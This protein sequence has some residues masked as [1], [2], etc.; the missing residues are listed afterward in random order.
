MIAAN[1]KRVNLR[2]DS[3]EHHHEVQ[4]IAVSKTRSNSEI[5]EAVN[6]WSSSFWRKLFTRIP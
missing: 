1:L 4:L 5:Q 3:I 2:I 6:C